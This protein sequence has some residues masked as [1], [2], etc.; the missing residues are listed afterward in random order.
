VR[1][2]TLERGVHLK[3]GRNGGERGE[4]KRIGVSRDV[5][6]AFKGRRPRARTE[7]RKRILQL[8]QSLSTLPW[9]PRSQFDSS[10][11]AKLRRPCKRARLKRLQD[12][13][14]LVLKKVREE[15][16]A[17]EAII[18][19]VDQRDKQNPMEK[20]LQKNTQKTRKRV[21]PDYILIGDVH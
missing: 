7:K 3:A 12:S 9:N 1:A 6:K 5:E 21:P 14:L 18:E 17:T 2:L 10:S 13:D 15:A 16:I 19:M 11:R 8:T 20:V 4:T